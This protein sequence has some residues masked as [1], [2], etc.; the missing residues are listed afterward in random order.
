MS[1]PHIIAEACTNHNGSLAKAK[2]LVDLAAASGADS[3]KFQIIN[4]EGLY[5]LR[6]RDESGAWVENGVVAQRRAAMLTDDEYRELA[7][8]ARAKGI[9][10]SGS[11]FDRKSL[12]LL[13]EID[14]PYLKIASTDC[15]N[16]PFLAEV[17]ARGR[18]IILATGMA[19]LGEVERAVK[20]ITD[21]GN[22][23]LVLLHCVSVYPCPLDLVNL[24][25]IATLRAAFGLPVGF[26]DHTSASLAA[27]M[28]VALGAE[29]FEKHYTWDR[30]APGF[31]HANSLDP[32]QL[33]AYVADIRAATAAM[34]RPSAKVGEKEAG[35]RA[36]ARRALHAGRDLAAG[37][38][39]TERDVLI[40][41][42]EGPL[43]PGD[44][45]LIVGRRLK[46]GLAQF[47]PFSLDALE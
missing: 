11:V 18:K 27:A 30:T 35:V 19:S 23:D 45:G 12:D 6:V 28:A 17:A 3:V 21:A 34:T 29:W 47:E 22:S 33:N 43:A 5:L 46:R 31:D 36:R 37:E 20:T 15:N 32:Q 10:L 7:A 39:I 42:P 44:L 41:R 2:E 26:S 4:P 40:V 24:G 25:H 38:T 1:T 8:H 13:C 9:P 14:A 16:Y